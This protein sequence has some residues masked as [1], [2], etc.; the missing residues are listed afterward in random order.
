MVKE[1]LYITVPSVFRCPISLDVM[2]SPVSL[3]TGVTYDRSSIQQ[4]LESGHNTCPAT[5]QL[6]PSKD[7]IPNLTLHRLINLWI[8]SSTLLPGANSPRLLPAT[9]PEITQVRAKLLMEKIE[10]QC[11]AESLSKLSEFVSYCEENRRFVV[12]FHGF[13]EVIAGVLI[14]K[15]VEI[16]ALEMTV[17]ILDLILSENGIKERLNKLILKSNQESN[18]LSTIVFILQNGS[19]DSKVRSVR[20]LDSLAL[21]SE[22]KR[23]ISDSQDLLSVLLQLLQTNNDQSLNDAVTSILTTVSVTRSIK[24]RL[25]ENGVVEI[26]SNTMTEKSLKL[27]ATLS[28]SSEGRSAISSNPKCT[29]AIVEKLLKV[30]KTAT[31]DAVVVLWRGCCLQK[32]EKVKEAVVKGNGVTKILVI[33]QR[34]GEGRVKMMCSDLVKAVRAACKDWSLGSYETKTTHIRPC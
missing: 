33:M 7:F 27:L 24:S 9:F 30:S 23:R 6:L 32:E 17:G 34:E 1:E 20:V 3:C 5:M 2:K 28:S 19:P 10:S 14:R 8:Q 29:A 15:C 13:V 21:D 11:C 4:W 16:E 26:L 25:I 31:E 22:S 12:R 18:F